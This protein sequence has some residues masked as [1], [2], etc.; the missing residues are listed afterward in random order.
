[1]HRRF[2]L[3]MCHVSLIPLTWCGLLLGLVGLQ[4]LDG[5]QIRWSS[6]GTGAEARDAQHLVRIDENCLGCSISGTSSG[7][8][9]PVESESLPE[10]CSPMPD[11]SSSGL[12]KKFDE[13]KSLKKLMRVVARD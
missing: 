2:V 3:Q 12:S 9:A 7:R 11:A 8:Q 13:S 6:S 5:S 10:I 1:M 4:L